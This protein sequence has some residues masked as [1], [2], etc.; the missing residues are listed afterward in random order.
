MGET[1]MID[2]QAIGAGLMGGEFFL[3]YQPIV[4]LE[5]NRCI[6]AEALSR[7]RRPSGV[8]MPS[9]FI[10]QM[11]NTPLS[12]LLTYW[13]LD[14]VARELGPW[15]RANS[16]VQIGINVPPEI[17]GRGG[18]H[19]AAVN[20]GLMDVV[21]KVVLEITERGVPDKIGVDTLNAMAGSRVRVALDDV[22]LSGAHWV[23]LSGVKVAII[24]ID[25]VSAAQM[26]ARGESQS[27]TDSLAA[28]MGASDLEIVVECVESADQAE[29]LR[30]SGIRQ[31]QGLHF[32]PPLAA[33]AFEAYFYSHQ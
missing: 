33:K 17:L 2:L 7:W 22:D 32:S 20:S 10:P 9:D 4:S 3:E 14:T 31:A 28:L 13:V 23:I 6:G 19:Y 29:F 8:V 5:S 27:I 24:K 1:G 30:K 26:I 15:L 16:D 11:E 12:G 18:M 21:D 25:C